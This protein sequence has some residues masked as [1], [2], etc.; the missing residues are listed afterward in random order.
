MKSR[1]TRSDPEHYRILQ[2]IV[3]ARILALS[4]LFS[5]I[6]NPL[7]GGG[8]PGRAANDNDHGP[9]SRS[10]ERPARPWTGKTWGV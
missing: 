3:P 2:P 10:S 4:T 1:Q 7:I 5:M 8:G 6:A 9:G